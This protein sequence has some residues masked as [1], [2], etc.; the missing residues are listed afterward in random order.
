MSDYTQT[1][2]FSAKDALPSGDPS[3]TILGADHDT[4]FGNIEAAVATKANKIISITTDNLLVMDATGD[5]AD[6]GIAKA[7]VVCSENGLSVSIAQLNN[8]AATSSSTAE[9]DKLDGCTVS[10]AQIN[11]ACSTSASTAELNYAD[12]P[13]T[14]SKF[15]L[16]DSNARV[17]F[18]QRSS[19]RGCLVYRN[20]SGTQASLDLLGWGAEAY[21]T[22][23]IHSTSTNTERLTVPSGVS[24]VRISTSLRLSASSSGDIGI[25]LRKNGSGVGI[26]GAMI[27]GG[28]NFS[29]TAYDT[30]AYV[31]PILAVTG[32]DYFE[33]YNTIAGSFTLTGYDSGSGQPSWFAME[34]IQ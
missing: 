13:N 17:P 6:A 18:D 24:Y 7:N 16:L 15:L 11:N 3:K 32:G 8:A 2:D 27:I 14:A 5:L 26:P 29:S 21:D 31:S 10:T 30:V 20:T 33:L 23:N 19:V 9:L 25:Q 22:D 28:S 12:G 1:T 4:E 34:I